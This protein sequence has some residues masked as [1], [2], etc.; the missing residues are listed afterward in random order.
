M[1]LPPLSLDVMSSTGGSP[2]TGNSDP[3]VG[4]PGMNQ[5]VLLSVSRPHPFACAYTIPPWNAFAFHRSRLEGQSLSW[6]MKR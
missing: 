3:V 6:S 2:M 1:A 5:T 4:A